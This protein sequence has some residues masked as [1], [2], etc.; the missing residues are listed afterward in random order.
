MCSQN[1]RDL[2]RAVP[3][4]CRSWRR[5]SLSPLLLRE[6][7]I[8]LR[9]LSLPRLRSLCDWLVLQAAGHVRQLDIDVHVVAILPEQ[10]EEWHELV[11]AMLAGCGAAGSLEHLSLGMSNEFG[12]HLPSTAVVALRTLRT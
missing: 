6:L 12:L 2:Y 8:W 3:L 9:Q 7:T 5:L 11:S 1:A 10:Q 4:V